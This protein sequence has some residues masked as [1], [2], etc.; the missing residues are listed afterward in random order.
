VFYLSR[1]EARY[2]QKKML[3][4]AFSRWFAIVRWKKPIFP[5][6]RENKKKKGKRGEGEEKMLYKRAIS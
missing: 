3:A 4:R 6:T 5:V 2:L 1:S